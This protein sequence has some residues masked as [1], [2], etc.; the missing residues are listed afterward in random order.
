[1]SRLSG[2]APARENRGQSG[3]TDLAGTDAIHLVRDSGDITPAMP[4]FV[5]AF[6]QAELT[7]QLA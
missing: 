7:S 3:R 2:E 1:M 5:A 4:A 6:L